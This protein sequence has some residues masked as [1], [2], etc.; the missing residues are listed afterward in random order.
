M[1]KIRYN[2]KSATYLNK[3]NKITVLKLI[4]E[5]KEISRAEIV[6]KTKLSAP[7]V[8]RIVDVLVNDRLVAMLGDGDSSGGRP[9]KL[10]KFDGTNNYVIGV[11]LGSTSIRAAL[12][13]LNGDFVTEIEAPTQLGRG[14]EIIIQQVA[15]LIDKLINRSKLSKKSILGI[16][17]AVAG[18]INPQKGFVKYSPVF[19]WKDVQLDAIL[20][21]YIDL[22]V[23]FDNVSR[24][25]ALGE[26]YYG[27]G[28]RYKNYISVNVGYGIGA[29][30]VI[31]SKPMYGNFGYAGEFGHIVLERNSQFVGKDGIRGSL[32]ALAS[33]YGIA[34]I[35][36]NQ[37][38]QGQKSELSNLS[39]KELTA[40]A[41]FNAA[42]KGD[43]LAK[44]II[45]NA[46]QYLGQGVAL[47]INIFDPQAI[48]FSGGLTK[49]GPSFFKAIEKY[50]LDY[51]FKGE[52]SRSVKI[53]PSSFQDDASLMGAFSLITSKVLNFDS[54]FY[55]N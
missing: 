35:A 25:T 14:V 48:V 51:Q 19:K 44:E 8:T 2:G 1:S 50:A 7:T 47:L 13:D 39:E 28:K 46:L 16:G 36:R 23:I 22:P 49:S 12:S 18:L 42:K 32:E 37:L 4:R 6:K 24:I 55:V 54:E 53:L 9:P 10:L 31:D 43:K 34:E 17:L 33:G 27:I 38:K 30:I 26:M 11:D 21:K 3:L 20:K 41:V 52:G 5:S 15:A 29:G 45:D 40:E